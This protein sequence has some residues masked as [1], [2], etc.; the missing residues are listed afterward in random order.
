M[1][2]PCN[3]SKEVGMSKDILMGN[4]MINH[5]KHTHTYIH[6]YI[7]IVYNSKIESGFNL[8]FALAMV[9]ARHQLDTARILAAQYVDAW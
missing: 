9:N 2:L 1:K 3:L 4:T 5:G 6:I 7:R 8:R